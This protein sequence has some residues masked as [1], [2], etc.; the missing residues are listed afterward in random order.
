MNKWKNL[1][2]KVSATWDKVSSADETSEQREKNGKKLTVD[3]SVIIS[4]LLNNEI[5]HKE[6]LI[7]SAKRF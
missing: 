6:A 1:R 3:T 4:S 5:R 7:K 2:K